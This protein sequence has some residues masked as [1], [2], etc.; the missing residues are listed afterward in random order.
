VITSVVFAI[1]MSWAWSGNMKEFQRIFVINLII[2]AVISFLREIARQFICYKNKLRTEYSFWPFGGV[3][4]LISTFLGNTFSL[5]SYTLVDDNI[6]EKKFGKITFMISLFTFIAAV[7]AYIIN[8]FSPGLILQMIFVYCIMMLFIEMFPM[9]P[10][11]G[12][13][14]RKWKF[15]TWLVF[16]I[17]VIVSYIYVN[18]TAY[19]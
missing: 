8:I 3:L 1:T 18:F 12:N 17:V 5:V 11:A 16:Y 14:I 6:D 13:D 15:V 7:I 4:T 9:A 2:V 10:F 19:V